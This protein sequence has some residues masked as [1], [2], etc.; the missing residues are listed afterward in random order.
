MKKVLIF[1]LSITLFA[2]YNFRSSTEYFEQANSKI[3]KYKP[4][5]TD[6]VIIIDYRKNLFSERLFVLEMKTKKIIISS[7]VS[8]AWNSGVLYANDY[9]N[10]VGSNK[11][12][13]GVYV[14]G[15]TVFGKFGYSMRVKGLDRDIND[16]SLSRAILFHS[17]TKMATPWSNGCFAT[18]EEINKKIIDLTKNGVLVCVID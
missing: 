11:S 17:T 13:K 6:Y 15:E 18:S 5:R 9:S 1:L 14:T 2:C 12:S 10:K 16:K 4:R 8:H 3:Q 7:K